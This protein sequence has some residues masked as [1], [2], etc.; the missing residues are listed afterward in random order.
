MSP[1]SCRA[2]GARPARVRRRRPAH[3]ILRGENHPDTL[4]LLT[5]ARQ[6]GVPVTT[7]ADLPYLAVATIAGGA[8]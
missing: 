3:L 2:A 8:E 5:L 7:Q 1:C 4:H 6:S